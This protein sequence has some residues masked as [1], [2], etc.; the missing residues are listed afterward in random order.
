M[1]RG[2]AEGNLSL[3]WNGQSQKSVLHFDLNSADNVRLQRLY[4][5][6][7]QQGKIAFLDTMV[8]RP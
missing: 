5:V 6:K 4:F 1:P 7:H 8:H 3:F 2:R